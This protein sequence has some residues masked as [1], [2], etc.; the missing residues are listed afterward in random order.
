MFNLISGNYSKYFMNLSSMKIRTS[1]YRIGLITLLGALSFFT[2]FTQSSQELSVTKKFSLYRNDKLQEKIYLHIDRTFYITGETLWFKVYLVDGSLHKLLDLSKVGYV[3]IVKGSNTVLQT[4]IELKDG[5]G[6]GSLFL[7]AT[8]SSG[9]YSIRAY[10]NWMKNSSP[11]FYFHQPLTIINTFK[12]LEV[13]TVSTPKLAAS[14]FPEGGN[15]VDGLSS[16]V[17]FKIQDQNGAGISAGGVIIDEKNDTVTSFRPL[18]Y[19]LGNFVFT[20]SHQH[21]YRA[22]VTDKNGSAN[23]YPLPK[24]YSEGYVMNLKDQTDQLIITVQT[25][26]SKPENVL[27]FVHSRQVIATTELQSFVQGTATFTIKKN[28]LRDGISHFTIFNNELQPVCERL[29]FK[30]P[31]KKLNIALSNN[32]KEYETREK[33]LLNISTAN[34]NNQPVKANLSLSVFR[35]DSL[36]A[37]D[38]ADITSYLY[39]TSDLAGTVEAPVYYVSTIDK[40][41]D[42]ATD[43]LMLTHG[44]RRFTWEN[45]FTNKSAPPEFIPEYRGHIVK[46]T[47]RNLSGEVT[48]GVGTY[49]SVPGKSIRLYLSRSNQQGMVQYEMK[50]FYG[51]QKLIA[52]T[53][54]KSDSTY[55]IEIENPYSGKF[56]N[57]SSPGLTIAPSHEENLLKR[58]VS[59]QVQDVFYEDKLNRFKS[60]KR[61]ST[62]FYGQADETYLLDDYTRFPVMEEVMREYVKG[63]WVRK[64]KD[65]FHFLVV[66]NVNQ[67][68]FETDPLILL[69]GV[70]VFDVNDVMELNPINVKKLDVFT[71]TYY[72]GDQTFPGIVSY[73]SFA[74][75]MAGFQL[76]PKTLTLDYEGLQLQREFYSPQ[77]ENDLQRQSRLPDQRTLLH[78]TPDVTTEQGKAKVEFYTSDLNGNYIIIIEGLTAEGAEGSVTHQFK[79]IP[80]Q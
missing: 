35:L 44:W 36:P 41:V 79:V 14:F 32:L 34:Q 30:R 58:A 4:K 2:A 72:L 26:N 15:L 3:E 45:I 40:D 27:L 62:A 5:L 67:S 37:F 46:G 73:S 12:S 61:D 64:R 25:K 1:F 48:K 7:P 11:E 65:G 76:N 70:P 51:P 43:N 38:H 49:L 6:N 16:K 39:L 13:E 47:V 59:M 55:K 68:V 24:I 33:I 50:N 54:I 66:D 69:D 63:V 75:D 21:E 8:L 29:Y 17:A 74:S 52:Q 10:T 18:K 23:S 9:N 20:P 57:Y 19:G 56:F 31:T 60:P 80:R 71:R 78:W 28:L 42:E 77:Y 53:N 22:V